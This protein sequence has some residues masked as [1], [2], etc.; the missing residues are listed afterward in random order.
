MDAPA[1]TLW[2]T[3]LASRR[4]DKYLPLRSFVREQGDELG[5]V[6]VQVRAGQSYGLYAQPR[7]LRGG[8]G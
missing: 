1:C 6:F 7:R 2:Y 4:L 5:T 8:G 3:L